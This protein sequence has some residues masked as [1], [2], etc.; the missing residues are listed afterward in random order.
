MVELLSVAIGIGLA[1][2]LLF[3]ELFGLA[4]GGMVV[5]L[6][7]EVLSDL[8]SLHRTESVAAGIHSHC[9]HGNM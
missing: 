9:L 4:A 2:S 1:V 3:S 6:D 7:I 5:P 8:F